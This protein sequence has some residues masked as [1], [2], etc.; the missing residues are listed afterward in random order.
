MFQWHHVQVNG[1]LSAPA[2]NGLHQYSHIMFVFIYLIKPQLSQKTQ[3]LY[4]HP[5]LYSFWCFQRGLLLAHPCKSMSMFPSGDQAAALI[6]SQASAALSKKELTHLTCKE[7]GQTIPA[8]SSEQELRHI[9]VH[10]KQN[11]A[12][13]TWKAWTVLNRRGR[14]AVILLKGGKKGKKDWSCHLRT[15]CYHAELNSVLSSDCTM[16]HMS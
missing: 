7:R 12:S 4:P 9:F 11:K 10:G 16:H 15:E 13:G 14:T 8:T 2:N 6:C 5:P 1:E 3:W